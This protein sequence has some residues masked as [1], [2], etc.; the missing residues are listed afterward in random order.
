MVLRKVGD[1]DPEED[2]QGEGEVSPR[3]VFER[4][5]FSRGNLGGGCIASTEEDVEG[6]RHCYGVDGGGGG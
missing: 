4:V 3:R 6:K 2:E 1:E 5:A